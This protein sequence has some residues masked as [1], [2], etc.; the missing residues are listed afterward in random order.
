M[1]WQDAMRKD[2]ALAKG[3][4]THAGHVTNEAVAEAFN[5]QFTPVDEIL[6]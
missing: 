4:N 5:M 3:L 6:K 1:G 2:S